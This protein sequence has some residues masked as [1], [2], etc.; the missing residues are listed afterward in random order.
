MRNTVVGRRQLH[1]AG[2]RSG[3]QDIVTSSRFRNRSAGPAS[4]SCRQRS[5]EA[6]T[7]GISE[8]Q[9]HM[10]KARASMKAGVGMMEV[11]RVKAE[12]SSALD[13]AAV[14]KRMLA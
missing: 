9:V 12:P 11:P 8:A 10:P 14:C 4:G 3:A 2:F 7:R 13:Q 5:G 1:S 6:K